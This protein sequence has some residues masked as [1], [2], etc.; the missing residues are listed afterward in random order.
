MTSL[1]CLALSPESTPNTGHVKPG[2]SSGHSRHAHSS[3][4]H[5]RQSPK[6]LPGAP[7]PHRRACHRCAEPSFR[8]PRSDFR[9]SSKK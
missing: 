4:S 7:A 6:P 9:L 2:P 5:S 1:F 3:Q 8:V